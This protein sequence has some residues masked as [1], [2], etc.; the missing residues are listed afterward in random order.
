MQEDKTKFRVKLGSAEIE[1]EGD[2]QVL[3]D[4]IMPTVGK[5]LEMVQDRVDLRQ[6]ITVPAIAP[7]VDSQKPAALQIPSSLATSLSTNTIATILNAST[8]PDLAIAAS[9]RLNLIDGRDAITRAEILREMQSA[10]SFY[11][12]TMSKNLSQSLKSLAKEDR[13]RMVAAD[14]YALSSKE[15]HTLEQKLAEHR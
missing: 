14:T 15:R 2:A 13:L 9:A 7:P 10:T 4:Q 12:Q 5:M 6:P 1:F 11:K 3:K 8:G